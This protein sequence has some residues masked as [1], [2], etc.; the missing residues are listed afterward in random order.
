[1]RRLGRAALFFDTLEQF[2]RF[3]DERRCDAAQA[4]QIRLFLAALDAP[5][6]RLVHARQP[7][8]DLLRHA[9]LLPQAAYGLA[10]RRGL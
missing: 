1:M 9:P 2:M 4:V 6:V 8:Q 10:N 7:A 3:Q 5:Q